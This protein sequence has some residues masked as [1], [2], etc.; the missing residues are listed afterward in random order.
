MQNILKSGFKFLLSAGFFSICINLI[1]LA[2]PIY[3]LITYDRVLFSSSLAT[4]YTLGAGVLIC[5]IAMSMIDYTRRRI[6]VQA[7]GRMVQTLR[8][9]VLNSLP[10]YPNGLE[11][12]ERLRSAIAGGHILGFLELPWMLIYL[13][14][15]YLIH[16]IIGGISAAAVFIAWI[17]LFLLRILGKKRYIA[18]DLA[19]NA[20]IDLLQKTMVHKELISAMG[21]YPQ[22]MERYRQTDDKAALLRD[23]A[24]G[25]VCGTQAALNLLYTIGL[26]LVFGTG[27]I[28]FFSDE[29][30]AG[31]VFAIVIILI[32]LFG[33]LEKSLNDMRVSIEA[34]AAYDRL[35]AFVNTNKPKDLLSLPEPE[36]KLD[37]EAVTLSVAGKTILHN[38]SFGLNPGERLGV[39]GP[40]SAGK[41]SLCKVLAGIWP[42][43]AG[44]VRLDGAEMAQWPKEDF[45]RYLGYLP[46]ET[47]LFAGTVAENIARL[48]AVDS[49]KLIAAAQK[50]G[51]HGMIVKLPQGYDTKID[52]TGKNLSAGQRQLISLARVFY[53]NPKFVIMDEPQTHLDDLGFRMLT[54]ALG[55]LKNQKITTIIVTDRPNFL[56]TTDKILVLKD[57]QVAMHGPTQDVL[58]QLAGN[59][60]PQQA[61]G[62]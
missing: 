53:G 5:L 15:L 16:P 10:G 18:A 58:N 50:A 13:I 11:D 45:G 44:K 43:A 1:Y 39:F 62:V 7:A 22:V 60:Q 19:Y 9:V 28:V 26:T 12:L 32:R 34:K 48:Q 33:P 30:T 17:V 3:M 8:P 49:D 59:Q 40:S 41:T 37:A 52:H 51:V 29:I 36:G 2:I 42:A 25:F 14:I 38:I 57:G 46:Q 56:V 31:S 21:F 24:D 6:M 35:K 4:L 55:Q 61:A 27:V 23:E 20:N 54:H 47:E